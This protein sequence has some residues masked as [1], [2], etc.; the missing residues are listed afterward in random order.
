MT[1]NDGFGKPE[2][3]SPTTGN[4]TSSPPGGVDHELSEESWEAI[5][6]WLPGKA[7]DPGRT[8]ADKRAA[9]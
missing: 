5:R 7:G 3:P 2:S 6:D 4:R 9:G 8:A 1:R